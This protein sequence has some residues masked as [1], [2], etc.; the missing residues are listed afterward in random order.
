[1]ALRLVVQNDTPRSQDAETVNDTA[2]AIFEALKILESEADLVGL[3]K[4]SQ[5]MREALEQSLAAYIHYRREHLGL[6]PI[7][8]HKDS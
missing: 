5:L 1:M 6:A 3:S 7:E 4:I 8:P 2:I